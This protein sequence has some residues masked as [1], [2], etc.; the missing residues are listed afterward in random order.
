MGD[1]HS[2]IEPG[3]VVP[4]KCYTIRLDCGSGDIKKHTGFCSEFISGNLCI[5]VVYDPFSY[6]GP[7][8]LTPSYMY[9]APDLHLVEFTYHGEGSTHGAI[10]YIYLYSPDVADHVFVK[11]LE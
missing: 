7:L 11:R 5:F 10:M 9:S 4:G 1:F 6:I 8:S 3:Y 2:V